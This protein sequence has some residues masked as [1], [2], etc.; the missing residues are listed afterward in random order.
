MA[1]KKHVR[2]VSRNTK[3]TELRL[4]RKHRKRRQKLKASG[5]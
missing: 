1:K 4:E 5:G 2:K 3:L